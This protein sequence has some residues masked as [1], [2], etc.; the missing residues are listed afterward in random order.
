MYR[1]ALL[2]STI[3]SSVYFVPLVRRVCAETDSHGPRT[4]NVHKELKDLND[5]DSKAVYER[6]ISAFAKWEAVKN[7]TK[8]IEFARQG[9]ISQYTLE[10]LMYMSAFYTKPLSIERKILARTT[11]LRLYDRSP[12][13]EEKEYLVNIMK[14][15]ELFD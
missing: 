10:E 12:S 9:R 14:Y 15:F 11:L 5:R 2:S 7:D 8:F 3:A 4:Q 13:E 6:T 1:R